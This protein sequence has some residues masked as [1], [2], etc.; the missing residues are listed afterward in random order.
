VSGLAVDVVDLRVEL[1]RSGVDVVDGISFALEP[2]QVLGLVGESGS[3]KTTVGMALLGHARRGARIAGGSVTVV[4]AELTKLD[5]KQLS[6]VRGA[7]VAYIP[8]DPGTSLNPA[9]RV[10]SQLRETLEVHDSSGRPAHDDRIREVLEEVALPSDPEFLRRYPHQLSGGQQQRIAIATAFALRPTVIVCDEP[11][12]GLDVTTQARVLETIRDLCR[13][14]GVAAV[15]VSHDLAVVASLADTVAVMYAGRIVERGPREQIFESPAHPYTRRLLRAVPDLSGRRAIVGIAGHPPL[16][17]QRPSG[18]AF[19]PRCAL[20]TEKCSAEDPPEAPV[21]DDRGVRCHHVTVRDQFEVVA[22]VA[23]ASPEP[24]TATALLSVAGLSASYGAAE[25]LSGIDF[26]VW[27]NECVAV[28]GE[29]G[30]GKTTLARC[31][32]GLHR[33]WTADAQYDG[34]QLATIARRRPKSTRREIQYI[35]QNPY[36]SLNPRRTVGQAIAWQLAMFEP[37]PRNEVSGRVSEVLERV[38]LSRHAANLFPDQLSGGERQ[39]VA[40]ARAIVVQPRVLLCDEV[41]SALDV[42]VQAAV[43][44][45]LSVLREEMGLTMVFIT[46]NLAL[47]RS[48]ADRVAVMTGGKIVER[49]TANDVLTTPQSPYTRDLLASTPTLEITP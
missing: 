18:C 39:R 32:S 8:Q 16:P 14:H 48:V 40:I 46:H 27:P 13:D 12:T 20:A 42:S 23:R 7:K 38:S 3:G 15:Y 29:S 28:V 45:L 30:S 44:D 34:A 36:S 25:I 49:G 10:G 43:V 22:K 19:H 4:G 37:L 33:Q 35:F 11:T 31:L 24:D 41:T 9:L 26:A 6:A 47:I 1:S 2:G 17:G 5:R 21:G